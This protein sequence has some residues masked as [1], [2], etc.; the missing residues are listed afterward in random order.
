MASLP[1]ERVE[2]KPPFSRK[3]VDYT[4]KLKIRPSYHSRKIIPAYLVVFTCFVMRAVH[5]EVDLS[6]KTE[7]FLMA[8]KRMVNIRGFPQ[9]VFSDNAQ[10]FKKADKMLA[11][12]VEQNNTTIN[13][14]AKK[15]SFKWHS[16][17][18]LHLASGG[19]WERIVKMVKTPL[20]KV[21][22]NALLSHI[23]LTT[24]CKEMEGQL[25]DR[26][27]VDA[28]EDTSEVLT[29]LLLC[30]GRKI[31]PWVDHFKDRST[32]KCRMSDKGGPTR[33]RSWSSSGEH[34]YKNT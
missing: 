6:E 19:V 2:P 18:E 28:S 32:R 10:Y 21:L 24:L 9:H 25:N 20:R 14:V 34:G 30:L 11:E 27:L 5:I 16:S 1:N 13:D 31:R 4:G 17:T 12:T 23:E 22:G 3:G 26:T 7:D 29:P 15:Y 8:F 33:R